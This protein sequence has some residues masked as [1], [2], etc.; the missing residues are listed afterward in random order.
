MKTKRL[1]EISERAHYNRKAWG[2]PRKVKKFERGLYNE[3]EVAFGRGQSQPL[4]R[5]PRPNPYPPGKRHDEYERGLR[6]ADPMGDW[7]GRNE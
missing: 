5:K 2:D 1:K 3:L 7:H 4:Y 6:L